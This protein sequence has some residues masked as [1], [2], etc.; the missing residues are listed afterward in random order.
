MG[1]SIPSTILGPQPNRY[2]VCQY[3]ITIPKETYG[4]ATTYIRFKHIDPG[5]NIH[6]TGEKDMAGLGT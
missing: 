4:N 6:V 5:V 3:F 1:V 2:D